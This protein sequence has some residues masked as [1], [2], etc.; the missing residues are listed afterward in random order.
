MD[1]CQAAD[2]AAVRVRAAGADAAARLGLA[3]SFYRGTA[4]GYGRAELSFLRWT[5]ARGALHPASGSPWWRAV[6]DH[7]LRDKTEARLLA[8]AAPRPRSRGGTSPHRPGRPRPAPAGRTPSS[9][10]VALWLEFLAAPSPARWFRAHNHSVVTGYLRYEGLAEAELPAERFMINVALA[11]VFFTHALVA[12]PRLALGRLAPLGRWLADPRGGSVGFFLDLRDA[13]P[14]RYPLTG[15]T[16]AGLSAAEGGLPRAL[17]CGLIAPKLRAL[18]AFAAET[19]ETPAVARLLRDGV[20][21]YGGLTLDPRAWS[22]T[23]PGIRLAAV[24]TQSR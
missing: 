22:S 18:Y 2:I 16:V 17:D 13:F 11:R 12:R 4:R 10:G 5:I 7:L 1:T 23:W 3:A 21:R 6:G 15:V 20:P 9:P 14:G 8:D 19:L 24:V